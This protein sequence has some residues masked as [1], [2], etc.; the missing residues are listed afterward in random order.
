MAL[1]FI[2][3]KFTFAS[4]CDF[5]GEGFPLL[6]LERWEL[7]QAIL[8]F[9]VRWADLE[10]AKEE[11]RRKEIGFVIGSGWSK[12]SEEEAQKLL[13]GKTNSTET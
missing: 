5:K 3:D 7:Y 6:F 13:L 8:S 4:C 9:Q 2:F 11:A 1:H 10:A 12:V